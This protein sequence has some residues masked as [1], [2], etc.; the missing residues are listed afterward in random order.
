MISK[1]LRA[2]IETP[3][4][5][6]EAED[7]FDVSATHLADGLTGAICSSLAWRLCASLVNV[8]TAGDENPRATQTEPRRKMRHRSC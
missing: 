2:E 1:G 8:L 6:S 5:Y 4:Q 3:S 7:A